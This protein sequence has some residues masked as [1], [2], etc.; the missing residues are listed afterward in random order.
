MAP[1]ERL[2]KQAYAGPDVSQL[3][4]EMQQCMGMQLQALGIDEELLS[5]VT[6]LGR[7]KEQEEYTEWLDTMRAYLAI[8]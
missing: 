7:H 5:L 4:E 1:F 8:D 3:P 2:Q 6:Q